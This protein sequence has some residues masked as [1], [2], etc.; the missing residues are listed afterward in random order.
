MKIAGIVLIILE[1]MAI[2]GNGGLPPVYNA[3][4]AGHLFGFLLPGIIGVVLLVKG[5]NKANA[6][7]EDRFDQ[8]LTDS[9]VSPFEYVKSQLSPTILEGCE[10]YAGDIP[11]LRRYLDQL[12]MSSLISQRDAEILLT[13][14][15]IQ[16]RSNQ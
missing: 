8:N 3:Y 16:N 9:G 15:M 7:E 5:I 12:Q 6:E 11:A 10:R 13:G 14:Y 4:S 1:V 2:L